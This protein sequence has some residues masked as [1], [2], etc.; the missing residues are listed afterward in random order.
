MLRTQAVDAGNGGEGGAFFDDDDA[1]N[2]FGIARAREDRADLLLEL[3]QRFFARDVD[4]LPGGADDAMHG[5]P[6]GVLL[7]QPLQRPTKKRRVVVAQNRTIEPEMGAEDRHALQL[8][9]MRETRIAGSQFRRHPAHRRVIVRREHDGVGGQEFAPGQ[10]DADRPASVESNLRH[11]RPEPHVLAR[12]RRIKLAERTGGQADHIARRVGQH[13]V[14]KNLD[15]ISGGCLAAFFIQRADEDRIIQL[16]DEGGGLMMFIKP[17]PEG[18]IAKRQPAGFTEPRHC[19]HRA[20]CGDALAES[21]CALKNAIDGPRRQRGGNA[22][23][24]GEV[25]LA[26]LRIDEMNRPLIADEMF[27]ADPA[28]KVE[29]VGAAAEQD[30]LAVVEGL[31]G[32]R[33]FERAGPPAKRAAGFE[34]GDLRAGRFERNRRRH[35][36]EA[37]ADDDDAGEWR[38]ILFQA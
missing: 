28:I 38:P 20:R 11:T 8:I 19:Q 21:R 15:R 5:F 16:L 34:E 27:D 2:E 29:Q 10:L 3:A 32:L 36:G 6:V 23:N 1:A 9:E 17:L 18:N 30:V 26:A 24:A 37:A 33:I 13:G 25:M 22:A 4:P 31:A 12:Q 35:A 14:L 7:E